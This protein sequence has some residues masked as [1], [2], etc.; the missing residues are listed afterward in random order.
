MAYQD[1][2]PAIRS[3]AELAGAI[4]HLEFAVF[5]RY[6]NQLT[7]AER[8]RL[9]NTIQNVLFKLDRYL[10]RLDDEAERASV[11]AEVA[12]LRERGSAIAPSGPTGSASRASAPS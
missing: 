8:A 12:D 1:D 6:Q 10:E 9:D 11:E 4:E 5:R 3:E 2:A 7:K